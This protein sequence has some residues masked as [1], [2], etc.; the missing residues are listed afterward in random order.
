MFAQLEGGRV[1]Q[2]RGG[3]AI[4]VPEGWWHQI[5][6][7]PGRN[8]AVT[9]EFEPYEGLANLWPLDSFGQDTFEEYLADGLWSSQVL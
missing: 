5:R 7:G 8:A 1:A 9:W 4:F 6:T 2:L 3:D